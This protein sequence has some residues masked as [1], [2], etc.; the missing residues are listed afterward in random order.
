[1]ATNEVW[2]EI[3]LGQKINSAL[4]ELLDQFGEMILLILIQ[5][6]KSGVSN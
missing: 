6:Y 4:G 5:I 2:L 1:M 3:C